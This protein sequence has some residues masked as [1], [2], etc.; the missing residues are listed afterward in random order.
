M[1]YGILHNWLYLL[2][3]IC[4]LFL[5][6]ECR[7]ALHVAGV[8]GTWATYL[9]YLLRGP[10]LG[11]FQF[12]LLWLL[13]LL[14]PLLIT[15]QYPFR[16]RNSFG[17][18]L[19]LRSGSKQ[20]WW[21]SKCGWNVL[22]TLGYL[23][24]LYGT[25]AVCCAVHGIP[26]TLGTPHLAVE[27]LFG[28]FPEGGA[29]A[30]GMGETVFAVFLLPFL[31]FSCLTMV[32]MFLGFVLQPIYGFLLSVLLIAAT[33]YFSSP[34][35]FLNFANLTRSGM[36]FPNGLNPYAGLILCLVVLFGLA[37]AGAALFQK[38]DILSGREEI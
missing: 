20:S 2:A 38:Q 1:K 30:L 4:A 5:F 22:C 36:L 31:A 14:I 34:F 17:M 27:A 15:L 23:L 25:M 9:M 21:F 28:S 32:E 24:L 11:T 29:P 3:P 37:A 13:T 35:L 8:R 10:A 26:V 12:Y 6:R 16:D 19:I 18:Y 33:A 7:Y